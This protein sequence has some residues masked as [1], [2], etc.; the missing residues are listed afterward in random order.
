[1]C[2]LPFSWL[3]S[4]VLLAECQGAQAEVQIPGPQVDQAIKKSHRS[5]RRVIRAR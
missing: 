3:L 5:F 2:L 1:M 4:L